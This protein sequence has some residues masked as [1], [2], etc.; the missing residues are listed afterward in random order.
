MKLYLDRFSPSPEDTLGLLRRA[1]RPGAP[2]HFECFTLEDEA[3]AIKKFG[4]T[5]IPA[6][7]Y[8]LR[9]RTEGRLDKIYGDKY[10]FHKGMLWIP[11]VP[12]FKWIY[13]HTG[14]ND[15]HTDGCIL[16]GDMPQTNYLD[17]GADNLFRS[18]Q[19][20]RR[21]YPPIAKAV[22]QSFVDLTVRDEGGNDGLL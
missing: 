14:S 1:G 7:T 19:A 8:R 3:R 10:S 20:Y 21:I 11:E 9:L 15:D 5:R 2:F 17:P 6:G 4:E 18:R 13:F 12:N 16:V 22:E